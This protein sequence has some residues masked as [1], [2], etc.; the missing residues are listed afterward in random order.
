MN[1]PKMDFINVKYIYSACIKTS[2]P[3]ITIL[4]DPWFTEGIYDGSWFQFPKI[5]RPLSDIGDCD[6][7]YISHIH[8]DH[9]DSDFLKKYFSKYGIKKVLIAN[10]NPNH[11]ARKMRADNI[12]PT[13][14]ENKILVGNTSIEIVPHKTGSISDIDSAIVVKYKSNDKKNTLYCKC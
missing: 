2:T 13:I 11:L 7:I 4:H 1:S 8:P 12:V 9:Y 14:L 10:H 3:D 6:Y 5:E